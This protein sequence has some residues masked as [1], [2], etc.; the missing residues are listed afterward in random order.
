VWLNT[1]NNVTRMFRFGELT[2]T[3]QFLKN[4][5]KRAFLMKKKFIHTSPKVLA[6]T[7]FQK[8]LTL[9]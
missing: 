1:L 2:L 7:Y 4:T 5:M 8:M 9:V 3:A 6:K